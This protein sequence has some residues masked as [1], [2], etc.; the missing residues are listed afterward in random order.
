MSSGGEAFAHSASH[1]LNADSPRS[2]S[3][4][5]PLLRRPRPEA[6]EP[7][8]GY[9]IASWVGGVLFLAW[10]GASMAFV[11][12]SQHEIDSLGTQRN[13]SNRSCSCVYDD[14]KL[15]GTFFPVLFCV[16]FAAV[17]I[18]VSTSTG[19]HHALVN[20]LSNPSVGSYVGMIVCSGVLTAQ[21]FVVVSFTT[22]SNEAQWIGWLNTALGFA[23]FVWF[24][25][26]VIVMY[27]QA[28][29]RSGLFR[30]SSE[31]RSTRR[32]QES[33]PPDGQL[34]RKLLRMTGFILSGIWIA[35]NIYLTFELGIISPKH[36]PTPDCPCTGS[37]GINVTLTGP[38]FAGL[39]ALYIFLF[40]ARLGLQVT[41]GRKGYA[42]VAASIP[43][44]VLSIVNTAVLF[45]VTL[46]T[47]FFLLHLKLSTDV[48]F[49]LTVICLIVDVALLLWSYAVSY[50]SFESMLF[51]SSASPVH[52]D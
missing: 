40:I 50:T 37:D 31:R 34:R 16:E 36:V 19:A 49:I 52:A 9:V 45:G 44:V 32:P 10:A 24:C 28:R 3:E 35:A 2:S 33:P 23:F 39:V 27:A 21:V 13:D 38:I 46:V 26:V 22:Q 8:N 42:F 11:I 41:S 30:E 47:A 18:I 17:F 43:A 15:F 1:S 5:E 25:V 6:P 12:E 48:K 14:Q 4:Q 20:V 29:E 51:A 7:S